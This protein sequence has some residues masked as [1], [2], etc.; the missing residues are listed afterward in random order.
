[1]V[2]IL[3]AAIGFFNYCNPFRLIITIGSTESL[4]EISTNTLPGG[5]GQLVYWADKVGTDF[6][7]IVS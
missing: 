1:M 7:T 4:T 6:G 3:D 2:S 5:K